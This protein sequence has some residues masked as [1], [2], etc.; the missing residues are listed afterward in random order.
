MAIITISRGSLSGGRRLAHCVGMNLGY[1]VISR[2]E[3]VQEGA[4]AYG[5]MEQS[6]RRG[7]EQG[8]R[9]WDRFRVDRRVYLA[10]AQATLC[11]L[12]GRDNVVYHGHAGHLL[13]RDVTNVLRARIIQPVKER[14]RFAVKEHGMS[15]DEAQTHIRRRDEERV[16]WTR[17]LYGIE[18]A[19]P[20]LYDLTLN[21]ERISVESACHLLAGMVERPE[22]RTGDQS[23]RQLADLGLA[24]HAHAKLFLNPRVAAAAAK[25]EVK[26]T[27]GVV[28]LSGLL[29][30][31]ELL[32]EVLETCRALPEVED[33]RAEWLGARGQPV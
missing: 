20:E 30:G 31:E 32:E 4:R 10:V 1:E 5:V 26:A 2:E 17:F 7:L 29:T 22:F 21:L 16:S 13:L 25:L 23:R 3:L 19:D 28:H 18:W 15:E 33:V 11:R 6:L 27:G 24:A 9:L 8:P 14:I 12:V